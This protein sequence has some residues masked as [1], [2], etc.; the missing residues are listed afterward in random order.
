M[1]PFYSAE[2]LVA[3][4][5]LGWQ[6]RP[7]GLSNTRHPTMLIGFI[8]PRIK[9]ALW[10]QVR[11]GQTLAKS[12]IGGGSPLYNEANIVVLSLP[13]SSPVYAHFPEAT[14]VNMENQSLQNSR[15]NSYDKLFVDLGASGEN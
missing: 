15:P 3:Q 12:Y 2:V 4:R 8:L 11:W 6:Q 14:N 9:T 10:K 7:P 1:H 13:P 5:D